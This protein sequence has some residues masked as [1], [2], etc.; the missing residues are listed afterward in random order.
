[1]KKPIFFVVCTLALG[2]I[3]YSGFLKVQAHVIGI[4]SGIDISA[5]EIEEMKLQILTTRDRLD[6]MTFEQFKFYQRDFLDNQVKVLN[7]AEKFVRALD[8]ANQLGN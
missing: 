2:W 5:K 3:L 7:V 8:K 1:M 6:S 4:Y